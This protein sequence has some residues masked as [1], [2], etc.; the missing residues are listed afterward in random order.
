M[1]RKVKLYVYIVMA[2]GGAAVGISMTDAVWPSPLP[3]VL[4]LLA[5][6]LSAQ[7]NY[8]YGSHGEPIRATSGFSY[9]E[10]AFSMALRR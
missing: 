6:A 8:G 10:C 4:F 3:Y 5:A 2:A 7:S 9:S 1:P